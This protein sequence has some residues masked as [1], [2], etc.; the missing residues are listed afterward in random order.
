MFGYRDNFSCFPQLRY[1]VFVAGVLNRL[2][3]CFMAIGSNCL[4]CLMFLLKVQIV[5]LWLL[6]IDPLFEMVLQS[7]KCRAMD[8]HKPTNNEC[9]SQAAKMEMAWID[10]AENITTKALE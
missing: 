5:F 1:C 4:R 9:L 3:K 8:I 7:A 2:V 6:L 10:P